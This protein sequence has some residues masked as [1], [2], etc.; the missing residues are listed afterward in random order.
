MRAALNVSAP[1]LFSSSDAQVWQK[2]EVVLR[3]GYEEDRR[4]FH[5]KV[6]SLFSK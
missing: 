6:N 2:S 4:A 5:V 3:R 1:N